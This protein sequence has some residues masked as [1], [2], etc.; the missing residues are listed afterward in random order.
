MNN[1][2][3]IKKLQGICRLEGSRLKYWRNKAKAY[4]GI[5]RRARNPENSVVRM[6]LILDEADF[7]KEGAK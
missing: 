2:Y 3:R 7:W 4:E 1:D 5:I 6:M